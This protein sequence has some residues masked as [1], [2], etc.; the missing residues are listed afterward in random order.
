MPGP[1]K[2]LGMVFGNVTHSGKKA[3]SFLKTCDTEVTGYVETP[4]QWKQVIEA[5][6]HANL[7]GYK[8]LKSIIRL[9]PLSSTETNGGVVFLA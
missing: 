4:L 6:R 1:A 5:A 3:V 7:Y 8:A 2:S 9:L